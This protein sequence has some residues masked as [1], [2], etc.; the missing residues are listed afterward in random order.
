MPCLQRHGEIVFNFGVGGEGDLHE[1][2]DLPTNY[3][4]IVQ[5]V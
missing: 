2:R 1:R 4:Q 5:L 3:T